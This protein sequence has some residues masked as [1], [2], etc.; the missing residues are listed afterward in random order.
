[1][2][3]IGPPRRCARPTPSVTQIVCPFG[4]VC[5][6][7]RAPGAKWT[8]LALSLEPSDGA[9]TVSMKTAPVNQ[10]F[11]PGAVAMVLR[12]TCMVLPVVLTFVGCAGGIIP[13][14]R[15]ARPCGTLPQNAGGV[16]S[17]R[18][19]LV[20]PD[21]RRAAANGCGPHA[22]PMPED[23]GPRLRSAFVRS[24]DRCQARNP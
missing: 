3:S 6:A 1:M 2:T 18:C 8:L 19:P 11:G 15:G 5:Q 14:R 17:H 4:C 21:S 12:V 16:G 24:Q 9:A 10:S 20:A 22:P 13:A 23:C 7:V